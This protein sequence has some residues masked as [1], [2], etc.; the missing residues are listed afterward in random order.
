MRPERARD[1]FYHDCDDA[2]AAW[3]IGRLQ[4]EPIVP[5]TAAPD[6]PSRTAARFG[7][8]PRAYIECL[9][10]RALGLATQRRMR[11]ALPC[12]RVYELPTGHSPFLSA[13]DALAQQLL[14]VATWAA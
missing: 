14:D 7:R 1:V 4:P 6:G 10:D 5:R 2:V 11:A 12:A 3:A 8:V 13:P 9:D